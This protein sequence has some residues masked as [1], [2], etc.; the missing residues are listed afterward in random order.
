MDK[1]ES[2]YR[3]TT[4]LSRPL[5]PSLAHTHKRQTVEEVGKDATVIILFIAIIAG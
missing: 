4:F 5:S 1:V 3:T 2:L